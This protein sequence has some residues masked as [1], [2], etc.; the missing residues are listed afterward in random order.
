MPVL[1]H[2]ILLT[3]YYV[4]TQNGKEVQEFLQE[5]QRRVY[6]RAADK[7]QHL[8]E[9]E[10][11]M[12]VDYISMNQIQ[13]P[14]G[15]ILENAEK[16]LV[17]RIRYASINQLPT[18]YNFNVSVHLFYDDDKTFIR[19]NANNNIYRDAL[20][21]IEGLYPCSVNDTEGKDKGEGEIWRHLMDIYEGGLPVTGVQLLTGEGIEIDYKKMK[22]KRPQKRALY[23]ARHNLVNRL[24]NMYGNNEQIPGFRL[25]EMFDDSL[26]C[27]SSDYARSEIRG[28][29]TKLTTFL[30]NITYKFITQLPTDEVNSDAA[31]AVEAKNDECNSEECN[32]EEYAAEDPLKQEDV[33]E[34]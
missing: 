17:N 1:Q 3:G 14:E 23:L 30:P 27:L 28:L 33:S 16:S 29:Q 4:A 13:R 24:L 21:D 20:K 2:M 10:I 8:L 18:Q 6:M 15:S 25:M 12:L 22:F 26:E 7:Y 5:I 9:H 32:G 11:E 31:A 19:F 34:N